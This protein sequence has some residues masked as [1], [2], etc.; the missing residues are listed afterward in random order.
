ML[1]LIT[2]KMFF[3]SP[4]NRKSSTI[5]EA[6][7]ATGRTIAPYIILASKRRMQNWFNTDLLPTSV[8][9]MSDKGFTNDRISVSWLRH[10]IRETNSSLTAPKKLLLYDSYGSHD[11]D[12]FKQLATDNNIILY[13]FLPYLTHLMQLLDVRC[14]QTYKHFHKLAV[15]QAIRN[16]QLTYDYSCF[17]QDLQG[18][19]E[20]SLTEKTI[21]SA[22][23]KSGIFPFDPEVVLKKMKT[24]SDPI[25][26]P[27]LP[28]HNKPFFQTP[29]TIRHSLALGEA[30]A[31]RIDHKLSSPTRKHMESYRKG[32]EQILRVA[33]IQ[34]G[35]LILIQTATK[36]SLKQKSTNRNYIVGKGPISA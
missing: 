34:Q 1:K 4:E 32:C 25:P 23:S 24:Y 36:A 11:T 5:I 21:M 15:H 29:K 33:D 10:F 16:M 22:W 3:D 19:R 7:S 27:E 30:L 14:F 31:K 28:P 6:I 12:E 2:F 26:E 18:I 8:F 17:L 20:K 9:D 35:D 13:M